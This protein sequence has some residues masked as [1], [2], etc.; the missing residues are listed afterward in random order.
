MR[1]TVIT[2]LACLMVLIPAPLALASHQT[3]PRAAVP[4]TGQGGTESVQDGPSSSPSPS[5]DPGHSEEPDEPGR[6][7]DRPSRPSWHTLPPWSPDDTEPTPTP[8]PTTARPS[9][10][11]PSGEPSETDPGRNGDADGD[12]RRGRERPEGKP[13][14]TRRDVSRQTPHGWTEQISDHRPHGSVRIDDYEYEDGENQDDGEGVEGY[15]RNRATPPTG[16]LLPVL[17]L[18]A[19]LTFLGLGLAALALRLRR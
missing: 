5:E 9:A 8:S 3:A 15:T 7:D 2:L 1:E 12:D 13:S 6:P 11:E 4:D 18:G 19:G 17:P 10:G 14:A 16:Q